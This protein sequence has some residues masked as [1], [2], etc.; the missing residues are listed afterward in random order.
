MDQGFG[1][2]AA[3]KPV[4]DVMLSDRFHWTPQEIDEIPKYRLDEYMM[5][6]NTKSV[7]DQEI[8]HRKSHDAER[9]M[10]DKFG[11]GGIHKKV[12]L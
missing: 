8:G 11:Q 7:T 4:I 3:P 10:N 12:I 6:L 2:V 9:D 1:E 5:V